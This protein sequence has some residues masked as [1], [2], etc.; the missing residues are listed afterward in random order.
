L[1][2]GGHY[3]EV[4]CVDE[5]YDENI[6]KTLGLSEGQLC[7]MIKSGSRGFGHQITK[8]YVRLMA[9][10]VDN[11]DIIQLDKDPHFVAARVQSQIGKDYLTS[12]AVATN[13]AYVNRAG[14]AHLARQS[15]ETVFGKSPKELE[16]YTVLD[17]NYQSIRAEK[18]KCSGD[19]E[20]NLLIHRNGVA[21]AL[22]PNHEL[23]PKEYKEIGNPIILDGGMGSYSY[24]IVGTDKVECKA[25][26]SLP[27]G[28]GRAITRQRA[29]FT[30]WFED[31]QQDL[32]NRGVIA[33]LG[34]RRLAIEEAPEN[35]HDIDEI[36]QTCED[37]GLSR[38]VVRLAPL[39][40][41]RC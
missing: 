29:R 19:K 27:S 40:I 31:I 10:N 24:I 33:R 20:K 8:D 7:I 14:L 34:N 16:M 5:I 3:I 12:L 21:R 15:F 32:M 22:P 26:G 18:L 13:F 6:A 23:V 37:A 36:V 9:Q 11:Q 30:Y 35:F 17:N 4:Q 38:S 2:T 28:A 41:I 1:G 25:L 39:V